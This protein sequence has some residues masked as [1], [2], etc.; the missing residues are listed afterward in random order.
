MGKVSFCDLQDRDGRLMSGGQM[1]RASLAI[2]VALE[3]GIL[4]YQGVHK[5]WRYNWRY[6][7]ERYERAMREAG[8]LHGPLPGRTL[9]AI[10]KKHLYRPVYRMTRNKILRLQKQFEKEDGTCS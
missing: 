1:R 10:L 6:E 9:P 7:G 5:P 4:H 2:G 8:L 3:P